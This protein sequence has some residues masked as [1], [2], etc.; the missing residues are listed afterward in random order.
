MGT[1]YVKSITLNNPLS[2]T[3]AANQYS[4]GYITFTANTSLFGINGQGAG[5]NASYTVNANGYMI[6]VTLLNPGANYILTPSAVAP[7]T[8]NPA[9][10]VNATFTVVMGGR[11]NRFTTEVLAI[12]ANTNVIDQNSGAILPG[13]IM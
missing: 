4:N 10:A 3:T 6:S 5:A 1:G 12:V 8:G 2:G 9:N 7:F 11:A 13:S